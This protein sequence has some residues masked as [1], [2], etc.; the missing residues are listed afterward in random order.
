MMFS[1]S[2]ED[3]LIWYCCTIGIIGNSIT[4]ILISKRIC[5]F[6]NRII[7]KNIKANR[8]A[9][10][11]AASSSH[12]APSAPPSTTNASSSFVN[13][14][15]PHSSAQP[16]T[17]AQSNNEQSLTKCTDAQFINIDKM[18][19]LDVK[20][21]W[22]IYLY[23]IGINI[24]D[25]L[26]L[27]SWI[28][29][30]L[31]ISIELNAKLTYE[32]EFNS[33]NEVALLGYDDYLNLVRSNY[34]T[35]GKNLSVYL[36]N[37]THLLKQTPSS[38]KDYENVGFPL[39][40]T[41]NSIIESLDDQL[42]YVR[43]KLIDIQGVC[44]LYYYI[45]IIS[46]HGTFSYTLACLL[47]RFVKM[48]VINKEIL[49]NKKTDQFHRITFSNTSTN[50]AQKPL[51]KLK[52][53]V[54]RHSATLKL[55]RQKE[56]S[57]Y[58]PEE[59]EC[60]TNEISVN[61]AET[62]ICNQ[63]DNNHVAKSKSSSVFSEPRL[64]ILTN[65]LK[66]MTKSNHSEIIKQL[67][68]KTS[69][70]FICVFI[71]SF[72]FHL[73]WLYGSLPSSEID[74]VGEFTFH[75]FNINDKLSNSVT[76]VRNFNRRD[77]NGTFQLT[78]KK[79]SC[80]LLNLRNH[81]PLFVM[82]LDLFLLLIIGIINI[83]ASFILL[84]TYKTREKNLTTT[85]KTDTSTKLTN[86]LRSLWP[87]SKSLIKDRHKGNKLG[88]KSMQSLQSSVSSGL[89]NS[90]TTVSTPQSATTLINSKKDFGT[91]PQKTITTI[92][93]KAI[94]IIKTKKSNSSK[95]NKKL[96]R[97]LIVKCALYISLFCALFALP[98]VLTRNVLMIYILVTN[99]DT[100]NQSSMNG[101][102]STDNIRNL[103]QSYLGFNQTYNDSSSH[104]L[105]NSSSFIQYGDLAISDTNDFDLS[106]ILMQLCNKVDFLLLFASSHK[107]FIFI[108]NCYLIKFPNWKFWKSNY[109]NK[110]NDV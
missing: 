91:T 11:N 90:T 16:N 104:Y 82:T 26:V 22:T 107:F 58:R 80:N 3:I 102:A 48:K 30:K 24:A 39:F 4:C 73:L 59:S 50:G 86:R 88:T 67:F 10:L 65:Q 61:T 27:F 21:N 1:E 5:Q 37:Q 92:K 99:I 12:G 108:Y 14:T 97:Y 20:H 106:S 100:Q 78:I 68:G 9:S 62:S 41:L 79:P 7:N 36:N 96:H 42:R 17:V 63:T 40:V 54:M 75:V 23:F 85:T 81:L 6:K 34:F 64:K 71:M 47:D 25:I 49:A 33:S 45:T 2:F 103:E 105:S 44:Q 35:E 8:N 29:S 15:T 95:A 87:F 89:N 43:I 69:A 74:M 98:S 66:Q 18:K 53:A 70:I 84:F 60:C 51:S 101:A 55:R 13:T 32:L 56:I 19:L 52:D 93:S 28:L 38:L 72:Y 31:F 46:L 109:L 57:D 77:S 110:H 76:D 83:F 94:T